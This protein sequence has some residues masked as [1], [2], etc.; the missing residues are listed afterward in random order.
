VS[1]V[2]APTGR[3]TWHRT[4][5][6]LPLSYL[7]ATLV[8]AA[9]HRY[10]PDTHWLLIHLLLAGAATNAILIWSTHF[11]DAVLRTRDD[12]GRRAEGARLFLLNLGVLGVLVGG[13]LDA[14]W[15]GVAGAATA[16]VAVLAHLLALAG[17]LRRAL[18]A[19]FGITVRYYLSATVALLLGI[20]AGAWLLVLDEDAQPRLVLFHAHVNLLGWVLLTVLGTLLTLWPTVLRTR[21]ADGATRASGR[22]LPV[23]LAGLVAVATGVLAWWP[24]LATVGLGLLAGGV[25]MVALPGVAEARARPPVSFAA[26][27]IAASVAWLL[28]ALAVDAQVVLTAADPRAAADGLDL[29][30]PPLLVGFVAQVLVGALAYLLPMVLGGG[31]TPVRARTARLDRYGRQRVVVTNVALAATLA[32]VPVA[33]RVAG[34][35]LILLMLAAFVV[36]ALRMVMARDG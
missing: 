4:A 21:M 1:G 16:F 6:V 10:L 25:L 3:A 31:P 26:W 2:T 28:V 5:S 24:V 17:R 35:V 27:S 32:P 19:R 18:P 7:A 14:G 15:W 30:L 33:V 11:T 36:P 22:A 23:C 8:V 13:T 9:A 12:A 20:P 34:A 29:V